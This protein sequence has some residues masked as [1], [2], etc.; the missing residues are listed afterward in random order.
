[1]S[2]G[3]QSLLPATFSGLMK[4]LKVLAQTMGREI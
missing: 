4:E 2:D 1:M 3:A